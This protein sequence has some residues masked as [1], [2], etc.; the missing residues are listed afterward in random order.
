MEELRRNR[1]PYRPRAL[2]AIRTTNAEVVA[3][4]KQ[5]TSY[6]QFFPPD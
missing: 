3:N 1:A 5:A 2:R 6:N 4:P